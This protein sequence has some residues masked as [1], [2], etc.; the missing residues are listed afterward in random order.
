[1]SRQKGFKKER[2]D[3]LK[4]LG[5]GGGA[6]LLNGVCLPQAFGADVYPAEKIRWVCP[7]K[8]G[9]GFDLVARCITPYLGKYLKE[10]RGAKGGE[11]KIDNITQAGGVRA[12]STIY[13]AKPDGYT[14]G[15]LN[16][17]AYCETMFSK[18]DIDYRKYTYV[19]RT[20]VSARIVITNKNGFKSWNDMLKAGKEKE[21]KWAAGNYGA[22]AH[23]SAILLKEFAKL[24]VRL[25]NYPG[26]AEAANAILRGDVQMGLAT[27]ESAKAL[28]DAGE[29]R[30]LATFSD[31]S[32]YPGAPSLT[33]LGYPELAEASLLHRMVIAPPNLPRNILDSLNAAFRKVFADKDFLAQGK[34]IDFEPTP[35]YGQQA[36]ALVKKIFKYYDDN[37]P[38]LKKYLT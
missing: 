4:L 30:V 6:V 14:V 13:N 31:K 23:M 33:Q 7:N 32:A 17:G 11:I 27:E 21:V 22:G 29:L 28:I 8:A 15:D 38:I 34:V 25:I 10:I 24:P 3:F 19:L 26:T 35:L 37:A 16:T 9:G 36:E 18:S 12:Y 5:I 1:M 2:R 20:G